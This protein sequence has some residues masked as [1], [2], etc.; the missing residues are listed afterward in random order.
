MGRV[1]GGGRGEG[2]R[3][4]AVDGGGGEQRGGG[5]HAVQQAVEGG[6]GVR[7]GGHVPTAA[8]PAPA[9]MTAPSLPAI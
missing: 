3:E 6:R 9:A 2:G 8:F 7:L 1:V 4:G 5:N